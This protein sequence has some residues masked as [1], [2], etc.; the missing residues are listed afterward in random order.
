MKHCLTTTC[1]LWVV[2]TTEAANVRQRSQVEYSSDELQKIRSTKQNLENP[3]FDPKLYDTPWVFPLQASQM[4]RPMRILAF[5][6]SVT[7]GATLEDRHKQ[8]YPWLLGG[9]ISFDYVANEAMR[10]TGADYPSLCLESIIND[11]HGQSKNFDVIL[12]DFVMNGTDGFP[13]LLRRLR[14]RYPEAIII[15]VHIWSLVRMAVDADSGQNPMQAK[16]D[17]NRDWKWR[18]QDTFGGK[19]PY[20]PRE[21]CSGDIMEQMVRDAGG[22]VWKMPLPPLPKNV[23]NRGWFSDDWHHLS[24]VGH[25][26]VA[27]SLLNLLSPIRDDVFKAPKAL[28]TY[29]LGDQCINWFQSGDMSQITY[30]HGNVNDLIAGVKAN[31]GDPDYKKVTLEIDS[32]LGGSVTFQSRYDRPVPLGLAYMSIE[33]PSDYPNVVVTIVNAGQA[34]NPVMIDPSRNTSGMAIAHVTAYSQIGLAQ[35]GKNTITIS[36]ARPDPNTG[37]PKPNPFRIVGIY[38]CGHCLENGGDMGHGAVTALEME[39]VEEKQEANDSG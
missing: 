28:G 34:S 21:V 38:L 17:R 23:I 24:A 7:W 20:C 8:A 33:Q 3:E 22:Y 5:G 32:K 2:F 29:G 25:Q 16:F 10:A 26:M 12:F 36:P 27:E 15:Y 4:P 1:L 18:S 19:N 35:P 6:G 30:E 9:E 14:E 39:Q 37:L 11:E 31:L 13:L